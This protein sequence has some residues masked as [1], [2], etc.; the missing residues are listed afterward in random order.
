MAKKFHMLFT[1]LKAMTEWAAKTMT[2]FYVPVAHIYSSIG[3][4]PDAI[5]NS[6]STLVGAC[7]RVLKLMLNFLL[8]EWMPILMS[9][10]LVG[11][12]VII[13]I[14]VKMRLY[15]QFKSYMLKH[16]GLYCANGAGVDSWTRCLTLFWGAGCNPDDTMDTIY[17]FLNNSSKNTTCWWD[18]LKPFEWLA[19]IKAQRDPWGKDTWLANKTNNT[20]TVGSFVLACLHCG[21]LSGHTEQDYRAV[22]EFGDWSATPEG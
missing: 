1:P 8:E 21:A 6:V 2:G 15:S 4:A 17:D 13:D 14:D 20:V 7:D 9:I 18:Q 19:S 3:Q 10:P 12:P 11:I 22:D 5:K 16:R